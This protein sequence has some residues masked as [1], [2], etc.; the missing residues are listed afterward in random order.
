M[1]T[2]K[3]REGS[4]FREA[5]QLE[6][7]A[8]GCEVSLHHAEFNRYRFPQIYQD[9]QLCPSCDQPQSDTVHKKMK[10]N[11]IGTLQVPDMN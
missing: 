2:N 1:Y 11:N 8:S 10:K 5:F 3:T 9:Q 7:T 4:V 6:S